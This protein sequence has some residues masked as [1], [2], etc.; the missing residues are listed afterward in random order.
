MGFTPDGWDYAALLG[1]SIIGLSGLLIV[2]FI[3]GL[4]GRIAIGRNHPEADAVYT[5]GWLGFLGVVPWINAF[6]W[7][8]KPTEVVDLRYTPRQVKKETQEMIA[9]LKGA[10]PLA[11]AAKPDGETTANPDE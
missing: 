7:A 4:P 3:L 11:F 1:L 5:M 8:F 6:I 9:R 2:I 10:T